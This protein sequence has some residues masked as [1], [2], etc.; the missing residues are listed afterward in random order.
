[1]ENSAIDNT[2]FAPK[3]Y[4]DTSDIQDFGENPEYDAKADAIH[5]AQ[6]F[7]N[8][9][10]EKAGSIKQEA[11]VKIKQGTEKAKELHHVAE[12]YVR[13]NPTKAV[14]GALGIGVIVGLIM[15]R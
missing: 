13:E 3:D 14:L 4:V 7:R 9:A 11:G 10:G 8:Y 1:M 6:N 2:S 15:R 5:K 12:D